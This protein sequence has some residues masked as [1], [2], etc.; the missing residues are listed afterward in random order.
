MSVEKLLA[1]FAANN[2]EQAKLPDDNPWYRHQWTG[3]VRTFNNVD[4]T[5]VSKDPDEDIAFVYAAGTTSPDWNGQAAAI[6]LLKD[7]RWCAW[8]TRWGPTGSGFCCDAYG[9]DETVYFADNLETLRRE[10]L[11]AEGRALCGLSYPHE[12]PPKEEDE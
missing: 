8:S 10:A 5:M 9:G 4:N 1:E 7:G 11:D 6:V 3:E 12:L 2:R